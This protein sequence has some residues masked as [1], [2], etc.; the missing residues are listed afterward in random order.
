[1]ELGDSKMNDYPTVLPAGSSYI[2]PISMGRLTA[3][4]TG[5][6]WALRAGTK[7]IRIRHIIFTLTFDGV[8]S[9]DTSLMGLYRFSGAAYTGGTVIV[10]VK[11]NTTMSASTVADC[12]QIASA[13]LG[14]AGVTVESYPFL[15]TANQRDKGATTTESHEFGFSDSLV[16]NPGEGLVIINNIVSVIGD[17]IAGFIEFDEV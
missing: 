7:T 8:G 11:K 1:M 2:A 17:G 6:F 3:A 10:P 4:F 14:S 16:L 12:R 13:A 15:A 9:P 5:P